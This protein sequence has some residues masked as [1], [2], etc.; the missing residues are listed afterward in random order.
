MKSGQG[1][2]SRCLSCL[3]ARVQ[4]G[5]TRLAA[6]AHRCRE[7]EKWERQEAS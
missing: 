2:K 7:C 6:M 4:L 5:L 1:E 3:G